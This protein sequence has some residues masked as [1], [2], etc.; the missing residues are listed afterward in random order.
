MGKKKKSNQNKSD[1]ENP[2]KPYSGRF[3]RIK[4][5][6]CYDQVVEMLY[7]G[8][9][10]PVVANFIQKRMKEYADI[11]HG[12]MIV[13]LHEFRESELHAGEMVRRTLPRVFSKA[14]KKFSN[15]MQE[16]ERLEDQYRVM[17]YRLDVA[18]GD[19]RMSGEINPDVDKI[20]KSM[21]GIIGAM[22]SI[23]MD[24]GLIGSRDLGTITV[25]AEN[26]E[27]IKEKYG[28]NAARAF[29][30]PVSR[31]RVLAALNAM[32]RAGKLRDNEGNPI[33]IEQ[34]MN[35][36]EEEKESAIDAEFEVSDDTDSGGDG[37]D[38]YPGDEGVDGVVA[39]FTPQGEDFS[40]PMDPMSRDGH[41]EAVVAL[42]P[43]E[44]GDED[45][46]EFA[47]K[48]QAE[49]EDD[50]KERIKPPKLETTEMEPVRRDPSPRLPPGPEKPSVRGNVSKRTKTAMKKKKD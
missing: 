8:Y 46:L 1:K 10:T 14:E 32:R 19:E 49:D 39:E 17:Q 43:T 16:L 2:N 36:S 4:T 45:E 29:A 44:H 27:R 48:E 25:S 24:L 7:A 5:L 18:H 31:G 42:E 38:V 3:K 6:K 37:L 41:D 34:K 30:D 26:V 40:K 13:R 33:A 35:L 23:K 20:A 28:D 12:T 11:T 9:P 50:P 47:N 21:L 22:H 15:K